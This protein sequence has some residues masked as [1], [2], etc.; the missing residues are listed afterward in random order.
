MKKVSVGSWAYYLAC[1]PEIQFLLKTV[2]EEVGKMGFDG[3][4]FGGFKPHTHP[5]LYPTRGDR[6]RLV[7]IAS[8]INKV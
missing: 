1:I 4:S 6:K 3:I 8:S 7:S 2:I 5:N